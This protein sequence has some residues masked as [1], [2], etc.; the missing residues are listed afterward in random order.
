MQM[1]RP[2]EWS[3]VDGAMSELSGGRDGRVE[4]GA[5]D[6]LAPRERG[7]WRGR[8]QRSTPRD[9]IFVNG[10]NNGLAPREGGPV[11]VAQRWMP[12]DDIFVNGAASALRRAMEYRDGGRPIEIIAARRQL[13]GGGA[14]N[15][16]TRA[17]ASS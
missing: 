8:P 6:G 15:G 12:R 2:R 16:G 13:R 11:E 1:S 7:Q 17:M 9:G 10:A 14:G 4:D 3:S 5:N